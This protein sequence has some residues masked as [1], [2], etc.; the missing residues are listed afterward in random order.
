MARSKLVK[1]ITS[2]ADLRDRHKLCPGSE[3]NRT[4]E[5]AKS[6]SG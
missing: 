1:H 4:A 3:T 5:T 2:T 6:S